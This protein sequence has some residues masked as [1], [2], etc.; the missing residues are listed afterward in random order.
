[1]ALFLQE[2]ARRGLLLHGS[3]F[4]VSAALTPADLEVTY[5]ALKGAKEVLDSGV[6]HL[7]GVVPHAS[8]F[9]RNT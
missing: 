7:E 4:N 3:G 9:R 2:T 5:A 6:G 8:L 1:M